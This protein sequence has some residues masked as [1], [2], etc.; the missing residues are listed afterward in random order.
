MNIFIESEAELLQ[1]ESR[2]LRRP[3]A[4]V[5]SQTDRCEECQMLKEELQKSESSVQHYITSYDELKREVEQQREVY[6]QKI[7][8]LTKKLESSQ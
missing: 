4:E 1:Q 8:E 2:Q 7:E 5:G 3:V 6:L